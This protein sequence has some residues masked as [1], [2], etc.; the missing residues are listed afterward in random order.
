VLERL[1]FERYGVARSYMHIA[2]Q[3]QDNILY[4]L[5]PPTPERVVT[6]G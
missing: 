2:G 3:S 4:Q 6:Y 5:L 1:G